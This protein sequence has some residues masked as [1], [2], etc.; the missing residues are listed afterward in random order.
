VRRAHEVTIAT[1][2]LGAIAI[3]SVTR[4]A[5]ADGPR[6]HARAGVGHAVGSPQADDFGVG[7]GGALSAEIPV[8]S[9]LSAQAEVGALLLSP[10]DVPRGLPER[11]LGTI[12]FV[13]L[14]PRIHPFTGLAP[15]G[16]WIGGG[17]GLAISG[18][19]ARFGASAALGWDAALGLGRFCLG[20]F[21]A[22]NHVV[23]PGSTRASESDAHV[24]W[25][26]AQVTF[27][28]PSAPPPEPP[29]PPPPDEDGDGVTDADDA[30]PKVPGVRTHD[31]NTNGCP[32]NDADKDGVP[33]DEDACPN[34]AGERR[35]DVRMNGC[36]AILPKADDDRDGDGIPSSAD[37]CPDEPGVATSDPKTNGCPE[38]AK[39]GPQIELD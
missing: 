36:P 1:A 34:L 8:A 12:T 25:G 33:D 18:S 2:L 22:Y 29:P 38:K 10:N 20:P 13:N 3:G 15:G 23:E 31:L 16:L 37:A 21:V 14:G 32:A 19:S 39:P 17:A 7:G 28:T 26:G 11:S 30:C 5:S 6:L 27:G 35:G 9:I 24:L 4:T